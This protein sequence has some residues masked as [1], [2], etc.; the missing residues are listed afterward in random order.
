MKAAIFKKRTQTKK[1]VQ[2]DIKCLALS[3]KRADRTHTRT[4][5]SSKNEVQAILAK[6]F[7]NAN[8]GTNGIENLLAEHTKDPNELHRMTSSAM[9]TCQAVLVV[10]WA[11]VA[12]ASITTTCFPRR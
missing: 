12:A 3:K 11:K 6:Q 7:Y 4:R 2:A 8:D 9:T 5:N 10:S 1:Y